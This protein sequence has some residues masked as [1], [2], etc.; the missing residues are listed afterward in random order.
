MSNVRPH[1]VQVRLSDAEHSALAAAAERIEET[2]AGY[3]RYLLRTR[4]GL[5]WIPDAEEGP[6]AADVAWWRDYLLTHDR[7]E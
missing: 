7:G 6:T 1:Q 4:L 2:P 3:L 5:L